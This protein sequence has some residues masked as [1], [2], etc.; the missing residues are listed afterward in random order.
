MSI[1]EDPLSQVLSLAGVGSALS[2]GLEASGRW[3]V[4]V[5]PLP[6]LKCNAVRKGECWLEVEGRRWLLRTGDC[7]L[8][9]PGLSFVIGS[10][11]ARMPQPAEEVF[12]GCEDVPIARLDAGS[13]LDFMCLSGRMD[14]P[15]SAHLLIEALPEVTI[16]PADSKA[17]ARIAWVLDRLEEESRGHFPGGAT[18]A[19][20]LMQVVF[21]EL[22]RALPETD[23]HGW[24]AALSDPRIGPAIRAMH[25][26]PGRSWRL[27]D[28]AEVSHLSR[29]QFSVR[30]RAAVGRSP[31]DYLL[32]WRMTL[33]GKA[34]SQPGASISAVA[35]R[36]GYASESAFGVA[37]RR[38]TGKT[39][40][41]AAAVRT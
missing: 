33:A 12:A 38:V 20:Q 19:A 2:T 26:D 36:L 32:H 7:F 18:M 24:L 10:D 21:I 11:L 39:P 35:S 23:S 29:S 25:A 15:P 34:L 30:F 40:R 1:P 31:M 3:A 27:E 6:T 5:A 28:L 9:A 13:G 4:R 37:F 17:A 14:M 16:I 8:V 22:I 41:R